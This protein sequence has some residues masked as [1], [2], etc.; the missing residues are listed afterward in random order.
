MRRE[1]IHPSATPPLGLSLAVAERPNQSIGDG[2]GQRTRIGVGC[3]EPAES[4]A[5]DPPRFLRRQR[6]D[7]E[8]ALQLALQRLPE[9]VSA[10]RRDSEKIDA[11]AI[12]QDSRALHA[13]PSMS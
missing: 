9:S 1:R 7:L 13:M 5:R 4:N 11:Q 12:D 10:V 8:L 6:R 3:V 2:L